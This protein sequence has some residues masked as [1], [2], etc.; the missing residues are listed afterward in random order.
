MLKGRAWLERREWSHRSWPYMWRGLWS[1]FVGEQE[2]LEMGKDWLAQAD[3]AE[4]LW[5]DLW[6]V[7][8]TEWPGNPILVE[9]GKRWLEQASPDQPGRDLIEAGVLSEPAGGEETSN[10]GVRKL[11]A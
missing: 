4:R 5:A 11:T 9:S 7:L 6:Q 1:F 2:F 10:A 3:L 8:W